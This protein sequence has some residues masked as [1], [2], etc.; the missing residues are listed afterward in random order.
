[1]LDVLLW[2]AAVEVIGLAAFPIV[3]FLL[4]KM[5]DRGYGFG[6]AFG[7]LLVG[8][9]GWILS[10]LRV[11]PSVRLGLIALVAALAVGGAVLAYRKRA[12]LAD[13]FSR[14][15]RTVVVS[16]AVFIAF[17]MAWAL[18]RSYDPAIDHTEQPMDFMFLNAA[19][20]SEFG[21]PMDAWM[22]SPRRSRTALRRLS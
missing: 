20:R 10:V 2:L 15:W 5:A 21:Q 17:F 22:A 16:E 6:K 1:M 11:V 8:Y 3:F 12:E 13:F 7:I 4:P 19:I 14:K 9:A 18:F